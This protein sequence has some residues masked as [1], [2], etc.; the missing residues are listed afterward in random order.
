MDHPARAGLI[1]AAVA[2]GRSFQPNLLTRGSVDQAIISGATSAFAYGLFSSG[3]SLINA[4]AAR[5]SRSEHPSSAARLGVA[6]AVGIIGGV[7]VRSVEW[8]EHESNRRAAIRLTGQA[9]T[10]GSSVSTLSTLTG[11]HDTGRRTA[12]AASALAGAA[13]WLVTT[14]WR[15]APGSLIGEELPGALSRGTEYFLEDT[16][17]EVRPIEALGIAGVVGVVTYGLA[18]AESRLTNLASR[19]ATV[20]IGGEPADHRL[21]GRVTATVFT[22]TAAYLAIGRV[23]KMLS[24]GGGSIEP[25]HAR[26]P[27]SPM[28]TGSAAS[29]LAWDKQT[30]EGARWLSMTL[31]PAS[32]AAVMGVASAEQP[33]R[34]YASLDIAE[35]EAARAQVLLDEIDR[36]NALQRSA[37]ALFSPTGSGYVNYVAT[38]TFEFLTLGDCASAA[39]Q[40]SVLPSALSLGDVSAGTAQT[41]MVIDGII[42]RLLAMPAN[43][44]PKFYLFGES[45]GSQVSQDMFRGSWIYG[46]SGAGVT[47]ALWIGTPS[48][49]TW[50]KELWGQRSLADAPTLG[51]GATYLPRSVPDW[52][53]LDS[54]ERDAID[55]LL[56]QNGDDPIPKFGTQ[57]MWRRPDWLGPDRPLGAPRST[58]WVPGTTFLMTFLDMLNALTPTP[59]TFAEGGHDYRDVLPEALSRT[60]R[61][62][63]TPEQMQR[64]NVAL[65]Q[66]ELAWELHRDQAAAMAKPADEQKEAL[67]K[68][69]ATATKYVGHE[70][71]E[72]E[73]RRLI[74][75]GLQ[76][77]GVE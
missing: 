8:R 3:D 75:T 60:W 71:D 61:L 13:S 57:V 11:R 2:V 46:P 36:T 49:S 30:R 31:P 14:P 48:A 66:R 6:A 70:V 64:I 74:S 55:Y 43:T 35:S 17:R 32:I 50:R 20:V 21:L 44:R 68:V 37:F 63:A 9:L 62:T 5:I 1:G 76:P 7:V 73:L 33:I 45:L 41:R 15:A 4:V 10:V 24:K 72:E 53:H 40:Y 27:D 54:T 47:A 67:Q 29:G 58:Q 18:R 38:E 23:S 77:L 51:P 39:I 34:V 69:L 12:L 26:A 28:I 25:G 19:V 42:K 52:R 56:L 59:G 16:V 22:G 65:R